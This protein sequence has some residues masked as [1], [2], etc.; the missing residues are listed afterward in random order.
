MKLCPINL[1]NH[2][3]HMFETELLKFPLFYS[4]IFTSLATCTQI[5]YSCL[6]CIYL[7]NRKFKLSCI[8][9]SLRF[10]LLFWPKA[11]SCLCTNI[12]QTFLSLD[13]MCGFLPTVQL[14]HCLPHYAWIDSLLSTWT[15]EKRY[16]K[17]PYNESNHWS[18]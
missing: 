2:L 5:T 12:T 6:S 15:Q 3:C 11:S 16:M 4:V 14:I 7:F 1:C 10:F 18:I 9:S 17:L 8:L 13:S